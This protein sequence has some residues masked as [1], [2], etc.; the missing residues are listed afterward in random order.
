M[1]RIPSAT[2][3][4]VGTRFLSTTNQYFPTNFFRVESN[5]IHFSKCTIVTSIFESQSHKAYYVRKPKSSNTPLD[6][7]GSGNLSLRTTPAREL[8]LDTTTSV[9]HN[10][11]VLQLLCSRGWRCAR[12]AEITYIIIY[13]YFFKCES[14]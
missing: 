11:W 8:L 14:T 7:L 12:R 10:F 1:Y 3:L 5:R 2:I 6:L 4:A 9:Y 13:I